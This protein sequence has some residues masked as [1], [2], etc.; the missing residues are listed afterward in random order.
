MPE[1][2]DVFHDKRVLITGGLGFIGSNLAR[3]LVRLGARVTRRTKVFAP[4][5]CFRETACGEGEAPAE[6]QALC[7]ARLGRS[8]ALP[9]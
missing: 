3:D 5:W 9:G 1:L 8:L 2:T 7:D 6:P 4:G